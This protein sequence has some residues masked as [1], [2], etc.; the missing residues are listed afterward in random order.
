MKK[1][2]NKPY[3]IL[4]QKKRERKRLKRKN[5]HY[6]GNDFERSNYDKNYLYLVEK[7]KKILTNFKSELLTFFIHKG[8]LNDSQTINSSVQINKIFSFHRDYDIT[9]EK[10]K[11][12]TYSIGYSLGEKIILDFSKCEEAD[13][14]AL[15]VLNVIK[16]ELENEYRRFNRRLSVTNCVPE[17]EI[18]QSSYSEVNRNLLLLNIVNTTTLGDEVSLKPV[19]SLGLLVGSRAQKHYQE[20][21]KGVI[22]NKILMHLNSCLNRHGYQINNQGCGYML[23][24]ISEILNNNEDHSSINAYYATA[25]FSEEKQIESDQEIVGQLNLEFLNFG[26]SIFEGF[27]VTKE[28]NI[29]NYTKINMHYELMKEAN[30]GFPFSKENIFTLTALQD[31]VSR[32]K[33]IEQSRGTGTMKFINSFFSFGDYEDQNKGYS[34]ELT[35]LSGNTIL[36]CDNTYKPFCKEKVWMLS[37]NKEQDISIPPDKSHLI[38]VKNFFPGTKLSVRL[39]LNKNH[40]TQKINNGN[41][42][43]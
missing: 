11:E 35:I 37:L 38:N 12:V 19:N 26:F 1:A 18:I 13:H 16:T 10:I 6:R 31:G 43:N 7:D 21:K 8:F 39:Y 29:E 4:L 3:Y 24:M 23:G 14:G 40:I 25:N 30:A 42:N 41:A 27:E 5:I 22:C 36:I 9:I 20:N 33:Y 15:F 32:L 17:F 2:Y 28:Q 34:P